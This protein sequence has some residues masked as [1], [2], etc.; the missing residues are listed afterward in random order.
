M[1][2][3]LC[4]CRKRHESISLDKLALLIKEVFWIITV[5]FF[6]FIWILQNRRQQRNNS[7]ALENGEKTK[8]LMLKMQMVSSLGLIHT[9]SFSWLTFLMKYPLKVTSQLVTCGRFK[10]TMF[11][12]LWVSWITASVYG[13]FFLSSTT[14]WRPPITLSISSWTRSAHKWNTYNVPLDTTELSTEGKL[15]TLLRFYPVYEGIWP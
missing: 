11:A 10:G 2:K 12:S 13:N 5:W 9:Y 1:L 6:P 7:G 14:G 8:T 3:F 15:L 4:T